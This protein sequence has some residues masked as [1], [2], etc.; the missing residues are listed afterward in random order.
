[1]EK[2]RANCCGCNYS[3]SK[4]YFPSLHCVPDAASFEEKKKEILIRNN[5]T[6]KFFNLIIAALISNTNKETNNRN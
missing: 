4:T 1:M 3:L 6:N 2:T 5:V